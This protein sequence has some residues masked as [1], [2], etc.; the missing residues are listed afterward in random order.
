MKNIGRRTIFRQAFS[1]LLVSAISRDVKAYAD[2]F[3]MPTSPG[4][5]MTILEQGNGRF[6]T[7]QLPS[8]QEDLRIL[9]TNTVEEQKPFAAILSCADSRVPVELVFDQTI[10]HLFVVRVAGNFATTAT[11]ASLEYGAAV[12][13]VK[14]MLVIGHRNCGAV[15][16]TMS[17]KAVP[18]QISSLYQYIHPALKAGEMD[19]N[20]ASRQN[21][22]YQADLLR[23]SSPVLASLIKEGKMS[24]D[25]AYYDVETGKVEIL[26]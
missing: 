1:G 25:A 12:L 4:E 21:A 3:K 6:Q 11:I 18:G 23:A 16:A 9:R 17:A 7:K 24:L 5:A 13:G 10:G 26:K 15:K 14:A 19:A 2:T 22:K 20:L 8:L